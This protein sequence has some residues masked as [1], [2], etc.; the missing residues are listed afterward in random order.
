MGAGVCLWSPICVLR[1]LKPE[2]CGRVGGGARG[3]EIP[4]AWASKRLGRVVGAWA[5]GVGGRAK[6][7]SLSPP[8][9]M[10]TVPREQ[11]QIPPSTPP[12]PVAMSALSGHSLWIRPG[13]SGQASE[14]P[15]GVTGVRSGKKPLSPSPSTPSCSAA[16]AIGP[17]SPGSL[18]TEQS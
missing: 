11:E 15:R 10:G 8:K 5:V 3:V 9:G 17:Q 6:G 13:L 4:A 12:T 1:Q 18:K 14:M 7:L 16:H 2:A